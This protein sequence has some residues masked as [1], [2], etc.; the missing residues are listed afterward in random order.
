VVPDV[1]EDITPA[2]GREWPPF[3]DQEV[4]EALALCSS[5]SAP[6][7]DHVTWQHLKKVLPDPGVGKVFLA[8]ANACMEHGHWPSYFKVLNSVIIPK[9]GKLSYQSPRVFRPIVLLNTLGKLIEKMISTCLQFDGIKFELFLLHQF[10]GICQRSTKDAGL[11]LT[12]LV[13]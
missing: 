13:Q 1:L 5:R 3:S 9:L 4:R 11:F 10:G 6:G 8:L 12:H 2:A 7:P